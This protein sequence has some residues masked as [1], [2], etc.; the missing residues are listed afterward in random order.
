MHPIVFIE[1]S[2]ALDAAIEGSY[3]PILVLVSLTI[4]IL[5]AFASFSHV[6]LMRSTRSPSVRRLWHLSGAV[7]MGMGVWTMHFTGMVAFQLP[8]EVRYQIIPTLASMLPAIL[9]G[10]IIL[11]IIRQPSPKLIWVLVGGVSMGLG[12]G[13]MHY[14]GMSAMVTPVSMQYQ[15]GLFVAS[16]VVAVVMATAAL[17]IPYVMERHM[18]QVSR[19]RPLAYKALASILMGLAI[20]SLHYVAMSATLF[21]PTED[22]HAAHG[23]FTADQNLIATLAVLASLFILVTSTFSAILRH[24]V[25]LAGLEIERLE[26]HQR[27]MSDQFNKIASRL[28]GVVYQYRLRPDGHMSFP[29]AS[30]A[31][32]SI[33]GVEP[34]EVKDS[35]DPLLDIIHP[36]DLSELI[37][38]INDSA[39]TMKVWR[40]EYRINH[41]DG[42]VRWLQGNAMPEKAPDGSVFWNGFITDITEKR[43]SEDT[44]HQLA[45]YDELTGLPNRRLLQD[46]LKLALHASHRH[47]QHGA[48]LFMDLDDFKSLNDT[49][50]HSIGDSL[51][52][53][54]AA[55]LNQSL[56]RLD[57]ISRLGGDEFVVIIDELE[58]NEAVAAQEARAIAEKILDLVTETVNLDGHDYRCSVS[59]GICL[60]YGYHLNR[61]EL[62]RRADIAMYQAKSS[63]RNSIRFFDPEIQVAMEDR[64][65][66]EAEL[67]QAIERNELCLYY[68]KQVDDKGRVTGAEALLRWQHPQRGMVPP[69]DFI[70]VAEDTGLI[71]PLGQWVIDQ[72]CAQ[73]R[74]WAADP[75][76]RDLTLSVNVSARQFHQEHFVPQVRAALDSQEVPGHRLKL[77]LTESLVLADL[78]D[79]QQKMQQLRA[80]GIRLSMDDFGTGYSS[81]AYLSHLLF[82]EVKIDQSFVRNVLVAEARRDWVIIEAII[83]IT[84]GLGMDVIAEGVESVEQEAFLAERHCLHFQ[85]YLYGRPMPIDDFNR[86]LRS[87]RSVGQ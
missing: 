19:D 29:W 62:L 38:S 37:A 54:I 13:A 2:S 49:L 16:L 1:S 73:I 70:P 83:N 74:D 71:M 53:H 86:D 45:F 60:F 68:Q 34:H 77:E 3:S 85:G 46:R 69:M 50:G 40:H 63:G 51:L 23:N 75:D 8:F 67:R 41:P 20:S 10:L 80:S 14:L 4:A 15:P 33:Y 52:K 26:T 44:I 7:A 43:L 66:L 28:P 32:K 48:I 78:E 39:N 6:D 64:F 17:F 42:R 87:A 35:I 76:T 55:R 30:E 31:I 58:R 79:T 5:A 82:D 84:R 12:I 65:K 56:R 22:T 9:A 36:D 21:I 27:L 61:E 72:A 11:E 59:I 47:A 24:R 57:T 81:M 25:A 18:S